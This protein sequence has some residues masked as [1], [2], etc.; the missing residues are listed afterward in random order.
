LAQRDGTEELYDLSTDPEESN[1]LV[2]SNAAVA[3]ELG[4]ALE[5]WILKLPENRRVGQ[6][7]ANLRRKPEKATPKPSLKYRP[8]VGVIVASLLVAAW[9][10][11]RSKR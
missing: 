5:Q 4:V 9:G 1:N 7:L 3:S 11:K 10:W 2:A 6:W 8:I